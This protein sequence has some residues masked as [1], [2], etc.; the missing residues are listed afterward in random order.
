MWLKVTWASIDNLFVNKI[1]KRIAIFHFKYEKL[2][3]IWEVKWKNKRSCIALVAIQ[4]KWYHQYVYKHNSEKLFRL[5][6]QFISIISQPRMVTLSIAM[7]KICWLSVSIHCQTSDITTRYIL[8]YWYSAFSV[9]ISW[10]SFISWGAGPW[11]E[12]PLHNNAITRGL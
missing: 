5:I 10:V 11:V 6:N 9:F 12:I 4:I 3:I 7:T 2:E 1:W 8:Y